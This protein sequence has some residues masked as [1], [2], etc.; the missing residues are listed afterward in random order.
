VPAPLV[1]IFIHFYTGNYVRVQ[2][3]GIMFE[4][5]LAINGVKQGGVLSPIQFCLYI[6]GLLEALTSAGVGCFIGNIF[7]GALVYAD[8]I[9]FLAPSASAL[10]IMLTICDNYARNYSILFNASKSECLV[11]LPSSRRSLRDYIKTV[12]FMLV[13]NPLIHLLIL[14]KKLQI[15]TSQLSDIINRYY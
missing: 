13:V 6:D 9:V 8:D 11:V 15:I 12:L 5:F 10:R 3:Y 1:R 4:Y 14:V 7:V 2:W